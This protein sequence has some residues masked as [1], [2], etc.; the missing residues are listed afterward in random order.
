MLRN[1]NAR[2]VASS[3]CGRGYISLPPPPLPRSSGGGWSSRK[4][5]L[6]IRGLSPGF[7]TR[8]SRP[9]ASQPPTPKVPSSSERSLGIQLASLA[10]RLRRQSFLFPPVG[11]FGRLLRS[12]LGIRVRGFK[13]GLSLQAQ[14][15]RL[16][17]LPWLPKSNLGI[18]DPS[19][20]LGSFPS[21]WSRVVGQCKDISS[22]R[23]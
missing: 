9:R 20:G 22:R 16:G 7:G 1:T 3:G 11:G 8:V 13:A 17:E 19:F 21:T 5:S 2:L 14:P 10:P 4:S 12:S 23:A 15:D 18:Q 6:G